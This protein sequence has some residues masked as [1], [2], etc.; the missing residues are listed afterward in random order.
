MTAVRIAAQFTKDERDRNGL[1]PAAVTI[2]ANRH[3][4]SAYAV[5]RLECV[6][7]TDEVAEGGVEIPTVGIKHIE[8]L[9]EADDS[10]TA[11]KLLTQA[12]EARTGKSPIPGIDGA[13]DQAAGDT[14]GWESGPVAERTPDVWLDDKA[15]D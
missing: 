4:W 5:V 15:E 7:V 1:I 6:R 9:T 13:A 8:L 3:D 10:A 2:A 11:E 12:Y 14:E